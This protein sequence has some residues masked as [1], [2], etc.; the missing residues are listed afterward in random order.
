MKAKTVLVGLSLRVFI[1]CSI[2]LSQAALDRRYTD[3]FLS[4][5]AEHPWQ[6]SGSPPLDDTIRPQVVSPVLIVIGPV[7]LILIKS[8]KIG[9]ASTGKQWE[10]NLKNGKPPR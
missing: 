9:S 10:S 6:E 2:G 5:P 4:P 8:S 3:H 7:K 1:F